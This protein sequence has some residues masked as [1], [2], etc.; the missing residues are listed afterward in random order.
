MKFPLNACRV[1]ILVLSSA[2]FAQ[3]APSQTTGAPAGQQPTSLA[4]V[5]R[6]SKAKNANHAK[7]VLT[8]ED[9][10]TSAGPLP[11]LKMD[12]AENADE[13]GAAIASYKLNHTPEETEKAVRIWY[14]R[15]DE[16]LAAAIQENLDLKTLRDQNLNNGYEL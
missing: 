4:D 8:D 2:S 9:M 15:Y 6:N 12:G 5:V 7:K 3:N 16:M 11:R 1:L 10:E 13:V 14:E